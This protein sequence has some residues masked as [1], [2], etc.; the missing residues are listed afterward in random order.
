MAVVDVL[1]AGITAMPAGGE[2]VRVPGVTIVPGGDAVNQ[3]VTLA[4]LGHRAGLMTVVGDDWQ[5]KLIAGYCGERGVDV[6]GVTV[7]ADYPT[8]TSIVLVDQAGERSFISPGDGTAR[9]YGLEHANLYYLRPGLKILSAASLFTSGPMDLELLPP[10]LARARELGAVTV[11]DLVNDRKDGSLAQISAVL[12]QLDYVMPSRAEA[13]FFA[14]T[15]DL[16]GAA[17]IFRKHGARNVIIKLGS[18]G[19]YAL[20]A[21][22]PVHVPA[23]D[24]PAVDTTGAGDSFVAGFLSGL[25][26]GLPVA[27]ALRRG[28]A[29]AAL[30]VQAVGATT[31]VTSPQQ[32]ADALTS[33]PIRT[34]E[35][36]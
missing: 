24:V 1:A 15:L 35:S 10:L 23:F 11:A 2:T 31:G 20:T 18:A 14:G 36:A 6:G 29:T 26:L 5:G 33:L 12:D 8:T 9:R 22:G 16:P 19:T 27:E 34:P 4:A 13:E 30:S 17:E 32:V 7:T 3:S 28:A 25:L 21:D